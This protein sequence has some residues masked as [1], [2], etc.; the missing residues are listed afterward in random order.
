MIDPVSTPM[1]FS[2]LQGMQN[3]EVQFN[4]AAA[5]IAQLPSAANGDGDTV[6]L[7][8]EIVAMMSARDNFMAN[9]GAAK[10]GDQL[11]RALLNMIA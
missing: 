5:K 8:A 1:G 2:S 10:S 7:S 6:D 9:V 11:Q 4:T 3:A